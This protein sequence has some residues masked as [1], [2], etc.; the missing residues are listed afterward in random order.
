MDEFCGLG[1]VLF[2][3]NWWFEFEISSL[4]HLLVAGQN[5]LQF[6]CFC[7]AHFFRYAG[8]PDMV[9]GDQ[10]V[11]YGSQ[12]QMSQL[13]RGS[14]IV[15]HS[16]YYRHHPSHTAAPGLSQVNALSPSHALPPPA[17]SQE[18]LASSYQPNYAVSVLNLLEAHLPVNSSHSLA[19]PTRTYP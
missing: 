11:G 7:T 4:L 13:P 15:P 12:Y 5:I 10:V 6:I 17:Q 3:L 19:G 2:W 8:V 1:L 16:D 18:N 14:E 9:P